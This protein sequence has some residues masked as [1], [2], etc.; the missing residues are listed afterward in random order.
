MG[1]IDCPYQGVLHRIGLIV[2]IRVASYETTREALPCPSYNTKSYNNST[3]QLTHWGVLEYLAP[4]R[5]MN[6]KRESRHPTSKSN[7][8]REDQDANEPMRRKHSTKLQV[9]SAKHFDSGA[10]ARFPTSLG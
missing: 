1:S 9:P 3:R 5:A 2:D 10:L 4:G 6:P 8:S 7:A